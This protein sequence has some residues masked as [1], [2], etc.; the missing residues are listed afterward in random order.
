MTPCLPAFPRRAVAELLVPQGLHGLPGLTTDEAGTC[1]VDVDAWRRERLAFQKTLSAA[2]A[3]AGEASSVAPAAEACVAWQPFL[4]LLRTR[5]SPLAKIQ[6]VGPLTASRAALLSDGRALVAEL[7]IANQVFQLLVTRALAMIRAVQARGAR[8][9]F[10]FDEPGLTGLSL[11]TARNL[12]GLQ[13]LRTAVI[14]LRK[15]GA[16][17]GLHCCG[18]AQWERLLPL[19]LH[20]LSIDAAVSLPSLLR[21]HEEL[22]AFAG[23]GG[24]LALG[25]IPTGPTGEKDASLPLPAELADGL[26]RAFATR[27]PSLLR[28]ALLTPACGLAL[29]T[30]SQAELTFD[31][32]AEAQR[33]L[34]GS[35][36]LA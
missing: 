24:R 34:A 31:A 26:L 25:I 15:T 30:V 11:G 7:P 18:E 27:E 35:P 10:F 4:E 8:P 19:G 13:E 3:D 21:R 36:G 22:K 1:T 23:A 17:V 12:M 2:I 32:L 28:T 14:A 16:L 9:I 33:V 20:F 6:L 5:K 29:R